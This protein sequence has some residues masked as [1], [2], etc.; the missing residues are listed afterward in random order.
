VR[1]ATG[2]QGCCW[3]QRSGGL[4]GPAGAWQLC[5]QAG[6]T[7]VARTPHPTPST[8]PLLPGLSTAGMRCTA[9]D[10][11]TCFCVTPT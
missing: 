2:A 9:R 5:R 8:P 10:A 7:W 6:R 1:C 11:P 3:G 4:T